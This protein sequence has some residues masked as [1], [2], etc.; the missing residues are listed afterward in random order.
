RLID[1]EWRILIDDRPFDIADVRK[2]VCPCHIALYDPPRISRYD[3]RSRIALCRD[4]GC[5]D[6]R[7]SPDVRPA[8]E[9]RATADPNMRLQYDPIAAIVDQF[10]CRP[11]NNAV[12]VGALNQYSIRPETLL[13]DEQIGVQQDSLD[14]TGKRSLSDDYLAAPERVAIAAGHANLHRELVTGK[15]QNR[16]PRPIELEDHARCSSE[17]VDRASGRVSQHLNPDAAHH[18]QR[19]FRIPYHGVRQVMTLRIVCRKV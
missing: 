17:K 4:G 3:A 8:G 7:T 12:L 10:H 2:R 13:F 15:I 16:M 5:P 11:I 18:I 9:H 14:T 1:S 19:A 6:D